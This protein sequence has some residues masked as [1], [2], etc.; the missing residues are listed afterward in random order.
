MLLIEADE[1]ELEELLVASGLLA[2]MVDHDKQSLKLAVEEFIRISCAAA[3]C[4]GTPD[5][6][7][8]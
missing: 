8:F 2:P 4:G 5:R 1:V 6:N 7:V 3:T